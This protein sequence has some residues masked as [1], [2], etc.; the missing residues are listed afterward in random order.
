MKLTLLSIAFALCASSAAADLIV[1]NERYI[2]AR[3]DVR[4]YFYR[5]N[6]K[7]TVFNIRWSDWSTKYRCQDEYDRTKVTAALLNLAIQMKDAV[8]LD[9]G[10]YLE[11]EGFIDC[12][13]F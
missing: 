5:E 3:D 6:G 7:L 2:V 12:K 11:S 9:F 10:E 13:K 4:G 1:I 8:S